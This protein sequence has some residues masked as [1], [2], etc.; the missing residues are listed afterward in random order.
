MVKVDMAGNVRLRLGSSGFRV[1]R[2]GGT[3]ALWNVHAAF[4]APG[5]TRAQLSRMPEG[6]VYFSIA[7]TVP[8]DEPEVVRSPRFSAIELGCDAAFARALVYADG[9]DLS[10]H[11]AAVPIGTT[12]RLCER[13]DCRQRALPPYRQPAKIAAQESAATAG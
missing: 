7:R 9:L 13:P 10:A 4:L 3:C 1:P 12:C 11:A 2:H 5:V 6:A 8:G